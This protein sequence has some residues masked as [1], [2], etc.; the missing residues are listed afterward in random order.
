MSGIERNKCTFT[1]WRYSHTNLSYAGNQKGTHFF[2]CPGR[3][4]R[5][6]IHRKCTDLSSSMHW[7]CNMKMVILMGIICR[8]WVKGVTDT[9]TI[10]TIF[11]N[12]TSSSLKLMVS[13]MSSHFILF[14]PS[15]SGY[16]MRPLGHLLC[17]IQS[18][19]FVMLIGEFRYDEHVE[20]PMQYQ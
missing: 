7:K 5:T 8:Q 6:S 13:S 4:S 20:R 16:I 11:Y 1:A 12:E 3:T 9:S 19:N 14:L 18:D 15:F 17:F 2:R 10:V